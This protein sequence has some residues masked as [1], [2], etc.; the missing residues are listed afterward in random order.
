MIARLSE[1]GLLKPVAHGVRNSVGF[2][3]HPNTSQLWFTDNGRDWLG[4]DLPP[5]ELNVATG[6]GLHFG[7]PFC[8]GGD[9]QDPDFGDLGSCDQMVPPV[10]ELDPHVA[11]LGVVFYT[12]DTFPERYHNQV[13]IAEHGS[14]NRK[15]K[16]GYR[17]TLVTLEGN[18]ALSYQPFA[19]GWLSNGKVF[20]RPVDLLVRDDGSLWLSDDHRGAVYRIFF[21]EEHSNE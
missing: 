15:E 3:W 2:A 8:H 19:S 13:F 9:I 7:F 20:G 14:W 1:E 16:I 4:D 12:A 6:A 11:P 17:V 10:R 5:G 21:D 18:R